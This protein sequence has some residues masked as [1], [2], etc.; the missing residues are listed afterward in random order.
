MLDTT[1]PLSWICFHMIRKTIAYEMERMRLS[2]QCSS[3]SSSILFGELKLNSL[4][5]YLFNTRVMN[6]REAWSIHSRKYLAIWQVACDLPHRV[7]PPSRSSRDLH[8]V[9]AFHEK[10]LTVRQSIRCNYHGMH[11]VPSIV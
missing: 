8:G 1:A 11:G 9:M 5:P 7:S 3:I 2:S 10:L 4:E 6:L